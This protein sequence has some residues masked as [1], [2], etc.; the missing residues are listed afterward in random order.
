VEGVD[1]GDRFFLVDEVAVK[2]EMDEKVG[3]QRVRRMK[4][5][6]LEEKTSRVRG[7]SAL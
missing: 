7:G 3:A 5:E 4:K 1:E 6:E 2:V